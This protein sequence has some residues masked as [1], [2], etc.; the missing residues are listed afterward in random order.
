MAQPTCTVKDLTGWF[1]LWGIQRRG[2][3]R[4][5]PEHSRT[6]FAAKHPEMVVGLALNEPPALG[7]LNG[8][9]NTGEL[10]KRLGS[11]SVPPGKLSRLAM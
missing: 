9:P 11:K 5:L 2:S 3:W 1:A 8:L 4:I 7:L 10:L 6:F